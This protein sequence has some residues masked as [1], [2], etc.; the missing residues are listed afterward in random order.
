M[1]APS[2]SAPRAAQPVAMAPAGRRL[3]AR[4]RTRAADAARSVV[5]AGATTRS[6]VPNAATGLTRAP[7]VRTPET[8]PA[9]P[10]PYNLHSATPTRGFDQSGLR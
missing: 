7:L 3:P 9:A 5:T 8:C 10:P 4:G 1:S 6:L 2:P